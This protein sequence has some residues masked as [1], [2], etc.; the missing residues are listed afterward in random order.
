MET[1]GIALHPVFPARRWTTTTGRSPGYP[2][3]SRIR[4]LPRPIGPVA[5]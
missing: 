3:S 2:G 1:D 5:Y 4:R